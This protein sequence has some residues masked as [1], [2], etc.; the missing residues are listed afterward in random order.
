[1]TDEVQVSIRHALG[2]REVPA[3]ILQAA[4]WCAVALDT[5]RCTIECETASID[6]RHIECVAAENRY[7]NHAGAVR[8]EAVGVAPWLDVDLDLEKVLDLGDEGI[9]LSRVGGDRRAVGDR[10][11]DRD[12][13]EEVGGTPL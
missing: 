5:D 4:L 6:E 7:R 12:A 9:P 3:D 1:M 8:I 11:V 10:G 2:H 13:E